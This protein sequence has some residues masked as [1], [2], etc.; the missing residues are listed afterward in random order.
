MHSGQNNNPA[1][2]LGS[3]V[4]AINYLLAI[5]FAILCFSKNVL[6]ELKA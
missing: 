5:V 4:G 2:S 6:M 3:I 1:T